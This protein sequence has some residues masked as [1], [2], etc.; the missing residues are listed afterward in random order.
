[1]NTCLNHLTVCSLALCHRQTQTIRATNGIIQ[2]DSLSWLKPH[3]EIA[4]CQIFRNQCSHENLQ[5]QQSTSLET[6]LLVGRQETAVSLVERTAQDVEYPQAR[7][8]HYNSIK[9]SNWKILY[10][11][12]SSS[13]HKK[14][15]QWQKDTTVQGHNMTTPRDFWLSQSGHTY[16][17]FVLGSGYVIWGGWFVK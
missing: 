8:C 16:T 11:P 10:G 7:G 14:K 9:I 15:Q 6:E 13:G 3:S 1:M 17:S 12:Q 4:V 2:K 5:Y